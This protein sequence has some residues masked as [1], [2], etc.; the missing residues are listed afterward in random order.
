LNKLALSEYF[1]IFFKPR[2]SED[3]VYTVQTVNEVLG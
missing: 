2:N 1:G 3:P